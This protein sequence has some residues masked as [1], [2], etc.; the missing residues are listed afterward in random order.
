MFE[1]YRFSSTLAAGESAQASA[2]VT[3][4]PFGAYTVYVTLNSGGI[5]SGAG[6]PTTQGFKGYTSTQVGVGGA[7]V[8]GRPDSPELADLVNVSDAY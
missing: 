7:D 1:Q 4:L 8:S 6:Q 2:Q 3:G 5:D